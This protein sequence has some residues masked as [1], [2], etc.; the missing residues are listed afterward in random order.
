MERGRQGSK[1]R[2][3]GSKKEFVNSNLEDKMWAA[4]WLKW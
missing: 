2:E 1:A 4:E 3:E